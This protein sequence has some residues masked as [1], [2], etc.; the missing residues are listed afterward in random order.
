MSHFASCC[1]K[2]HPCWMPVPGRAVTHCFSLKGFQVTAID[3]S[4]KMVEATR[5]TAAVE[6]HHMAFEN[7]SLSKK[8]NG[9]WACASL[10]HVKRA[11]LPT[12]LIKL[13]DALEPQGIIY[14]SFKHG[15]SERQ[16]D[17]RYFNDLDQQRLEA[18]TVDVTDL[19]IKDV[20][21]T[22]DARPG[23][24]REEWLNCILSR[25]AQ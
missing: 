19:E 21:I 12:V 15:S 24:G 14:A 16:V 2:V 10:L 25:S 9:I 20:W 13:R 22:G 23:R 8:F 18:L 3:A 1:P 11:V 6:T 17:M 4:E 5:R 7:Y